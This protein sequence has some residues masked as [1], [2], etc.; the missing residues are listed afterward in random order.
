MIDDLTLLRD[1]RPHPPEPDPIVLLRARRALM[2][3]A[4]GQRRTR[5][6][7]VRS[8]AG[9]MAAAATLVAVGVAPWDGPGGGAS[10]E[11]TTLLY[12]SAATI[13]DLPAPGPGQYAYT[14]SVQDEWFRGPADKKTGAPSASRRE[15]RIHEAWVPAD[16]RERW[17]LRITEA[18]TYADLPGNAV[19]T[20][21]ESRRRPAFYGSVPE[22][23][24]RMLD[25]LRELGPN[26]DLQGDDGLVERATDILFD[27]LASPR[28]QAVVV[29][30]MTLID[31]V[32]VVDSD[33]DLGD[34]HGVAIARDGDRTQLVLDP[35]TG[36]YLGARGVRGP[37][38]WTGPDGATY[39]N[40]V[41]ERTVV[42]DIPA[43][44]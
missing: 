43:S 11:A 41:V 8:V 28:L 13:E 35:D 1:S 6:H 26:G 4:L 2:R 40:T 36:A 19:Q 10:A 3:T 42:D 7:R 23:P 30:A 44:K 24:A 22:D 33:A 16:P 25:A 37:T 20:M 14:R 21:R 12:R 5:R 39:I 9:L 17:T 29:R 15:K 38:D 31:G 34:R 18:G 32:R 27:D